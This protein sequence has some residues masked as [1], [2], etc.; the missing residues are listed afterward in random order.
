MPKNDGGPAYPKAGQYGSNGMSLRD[1]FAEKANAA[2]IKVLG[3]RHGQP[4]Y[5]DADVAAEA[6]RRAWDSAD[7]MIAERDKG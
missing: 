1:S 7:A 6:A 4:G 5:S 2:W 3:A